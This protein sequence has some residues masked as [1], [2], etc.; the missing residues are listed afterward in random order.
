MLMSVQKAPPW[1]VLASDFLDHG[2]ESGWIG[3]EGRYRPPGPAEQ[4]EVMREE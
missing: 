3:H 4:R 1:L 2:D